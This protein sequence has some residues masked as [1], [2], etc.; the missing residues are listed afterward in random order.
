MFYTGYPAAQ[1]RAIAAI[2]IQKVVLQ[3]PQLQTV[4]VI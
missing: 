3:V 2:R 4:V 1:V